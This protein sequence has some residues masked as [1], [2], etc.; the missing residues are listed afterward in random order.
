MSSLE[1]IQN[2]VERL[3]SWDRMMLESWLVDLNDREARGFAVAEAR[4]V[5][6]VADPPFMTLEE[7]LAFEERSP[8][9][10]EYINGAVFAM[11]GPSLAHGRIVQRLTVAFDKHLGRR[12]PC[13]VFSS[14]IKLLIRREETEICYYP[15]VMV[16][17]RPDAR[18]RDFV[19]RPKLIVEVLS[20]STHL[21]D[22]REKLQNYR[23]IDSVEEYVIAAQDESKLVIYTRA[24]S[25][26]PRVYS[27]ADAVAELRSI[28]LAVP[29]AEIYAGAGE[30]GGAPAG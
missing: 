14:V 26:R 20:P 6:E 21:V 11:S 16:D 19:Q 29:L 3:S 28:E 23:L 12:G 4:A 2:S 25:W 15:D 30:K 18:G 5:Y 27:G 1:E 8:I 24:E 17:C 7:F 13:E 9:R 22:R 10:H